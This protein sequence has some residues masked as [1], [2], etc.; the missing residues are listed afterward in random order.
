MSCVNCPKG[1]LAASAAVANVPVIPLPLGVAEAKFNP[2]LIKKLL[3][4]FAFSLSSKA[5]NNS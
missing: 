2:K 5:F 4:L 1:F 3:K